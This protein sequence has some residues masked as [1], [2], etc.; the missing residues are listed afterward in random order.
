M[1]SKDL[2]KKILNALLVFLSLGGFLVLSAKMADIPLS[3]GQLWDY[4]TRFMQ[5]FV[6]TIQLSLFSMAVSLLIGMLVAFARQGKATYVRY[7]ATAYVELI[8]GTPLL[9][10]IIFFY[11]VIG[12]A[13]GVDNRFMSGVMI[14]SIFEGAYISEIIRGG[15][16]SIE[17]RQYEI[18]KAIG[19]TKQQ[20]FRFVIL[21]QLTVRVLPALAGQFAS[22]IKDSSL[23]STIAVIEL[24]QVT[25]EITANN[26]G[27]YFESYL[28][29]GLMY[30]CL[31]FP[32]SMLSKALEKRFNYDY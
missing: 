20:T 30:L 3:A 6:L 12:T 5:G 24:M 4:R 8:R 18:S 28:L 23:L 2:L 16:V 29:L 10:Q 7:L 22:V 26:F 27:I 9:V 1:K 21:P 32:V 25:K 15:F 31:T 11:Y 17:T 13:W 14:L 19:L